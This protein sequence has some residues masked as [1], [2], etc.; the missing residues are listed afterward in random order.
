VSIGCPA[1][2]K[3]DR[4][5]AIG[6]A[7]YLQGLQ[8][9]PNGHK[10]TQHRRMTGQRFVLN[11]VRGMYEWAADPERGSCMPAGF[12]SPFRTR[13]LLPKVASTPLIGEPDVTVTM[14][15]SFL[16]A[17]DSYQFRLFVP[18]ILLGLRAAEPLMLF[19]EKLTPEWLDV[20]CVP[21]LDYR[22]KGVRDK[23][24]PLVFGLADHLRG[25]GD[26][27]CGLLFVRRSIA[28]G[29]ERAPLL[30]ASL[31]TCLWKNIGAAA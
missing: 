9:S 14:A 11:V 5:F 28:K 7:G 15:V 1:A 24:L 23:R 6:F 27:A 20:V 8:V 29:R 4:T 18:M 26:P 19:H 21:E 10:N 31:S 16:Q 17:C 30:G 12:V 25:D 22:T 2:S 13:T 3:A